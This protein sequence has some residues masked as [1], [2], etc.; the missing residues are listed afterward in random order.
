MRVNL[1]VLAITPIALAGCVSTHP[2]VLG[3]EHPA[4]PSAPIAPYQVASAETL[5]SYQTA[6]AFAIPAK[7]SAGDAKART[8]APIQ[9]AHE[10]HDDAHAVGVVNSVDAPQHKINITHEPIPSIGWPS[11]TMDFD[12]APSVDLSKLRKGNRVNFTMEKGKS[13]MYEIQAIEPAAAK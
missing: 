6:S 9:L 5:E 11:M 8:G 10:G 1:L 4:N 13:G 2:L 12:V 3:A 7:S